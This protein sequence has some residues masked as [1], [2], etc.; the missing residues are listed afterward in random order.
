MPAQSFS[1]CSWGNLVVYAS[2]HQSSF[3]H[4]LNTAPSLLGSAS[5]SPSFLSSGGSCSIAMRLH[6]SEAFCSLFSSALLT[7]L[8]AFCQSRLTELS[9]DFSSIETDLFCGRKVFKLK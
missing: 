7:E 6:L 4:L 8:S 1:S 9:S 3:S 2:T 5:F